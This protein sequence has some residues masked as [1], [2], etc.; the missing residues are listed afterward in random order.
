MDKA[1]IKELNIEKIS[2]V[3]AINRLFF[4]AAEEIINFINNDN[5]SEALA[6]KKRFH[7]KINDLSMSNHDLS[8]KLLQILHIA[9]DGSMT[10]RSAR[11]MIIISIHSFLS[12]LEERLYQRALLMENAKAHE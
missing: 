1:D 9:K 8:K 2:A 5:L 3:I 11:T 10:D 12:A 6:G 7:E 4:D